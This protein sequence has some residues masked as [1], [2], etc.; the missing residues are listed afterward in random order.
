MKCYKTVSIWCLA[1]LCCFE[2]GESADLLLNGCHIPGS[3]RFAL[4]LIRTHGKCPQP[5]GKI[6]FFC[7]KQEK[8]TKHNLCQ[9]HLILKM[10]H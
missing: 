2:N 10:C 1:K 5:E 6:V 8:Q 9:F 3:Q 4:T 7:A